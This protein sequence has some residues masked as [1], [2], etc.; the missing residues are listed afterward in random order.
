MITKVKHK[1]L[2]QLVV[3]VRDKKRFYKKN[4]APPPPPAKGNDNSQGH[5]HKTVFR[6]TTTSK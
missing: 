4:F 5:M 1:K 3:L 2:K 6:G